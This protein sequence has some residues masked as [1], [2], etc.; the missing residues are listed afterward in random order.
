MDIKTSHEKTDPAVKA[1]PPRLGS[2]DA[3]RGFDMFWIIGGD[4]FV[5][6]LLIA[7]G[8][9][10]AH[11]VV[12]GQ[13]RHVP[14]HGFGAYDLIFPLFLFISGVTMPFSLGRQ[15]Q[16][17]ISKPKLYITIIRRGLLLVLFGCIYNGILSLDFAN[18]RYLSVLGFIGMA[19][20]F[21]AFIFI[22]TSWKGQL[23]WAIGLLLGYWAAL[24]WIDVPG[25]GPGNIHEVYGPGNLIAY[26]D[27]AFVP[28]R[29]YRGCF[30][31]QGAFSIISG[32]GTALL[33]VMA[34]HILCRAQNNGKRMLA[35][36]QLATAG[37]CCIAIALLWDKVFPINK[38]MWTS[39]FTVLT[40][41]ISFLLLSLFYLVI[42]VI[43]L[44]RWA[45][46]FVLIGL[47]PITIY[48]GARFINFEYTT[49]FFFAGLAHKIGG[50]WCHCSW[51]FCYL[52]IEILFLYFLYRKKVF[53]RV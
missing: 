46:P 44:R 53:L 34:G 41:G 51:A 32:I 45:F 37:A 12:S 35:A 50:N 14:W 39:S 27:R 21:A 43:G 19:W 33:G 18:A 25:F 49:D 28:G 29:L 6:T 22:N 4:R 15:I 16:K 23:S 48:M 42:D 20:M 38:E 7:C 10:G 1:K 3:L 40:A 36:G 8:F 5:K 30:D 52:L 2:L 11:A 31:P 24:M 47:N 13:L 26:L 17:G 9:Q